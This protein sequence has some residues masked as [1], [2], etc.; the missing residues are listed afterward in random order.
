[1]LGRVMRGPMGHT[2]AGPAGVS[3]SSQDGTNEA[4]LVALASGFSGLP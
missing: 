2:K 4:G 3:D 1:M